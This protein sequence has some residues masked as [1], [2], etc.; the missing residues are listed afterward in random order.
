MRPRL[1]IGFA[2]ET[3]PDAKAI[4]AK[5]T[6]KRVDKGC[7]WIVANDVGEATGTFGGD[8]NA[9]HVI[10]EAGSTSWPRLPKVEVA[11]RLANRIAEYF[12]RIQ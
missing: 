8:E 3:E 4:I 1:V 2:A 11:Q 9:V 6:A 5:A 7:D 10:D 12:T